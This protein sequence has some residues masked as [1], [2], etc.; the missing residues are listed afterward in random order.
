MVANDPEKRGL[1]SWG[2]IGGLPWISE[3]SKKDSN[4]QFQWTPKCAMIGLK[5]PFLDFYVVGMVM[6][7]IERG[8]NTYI[9]IQHVYIYTNMCVYVNP[10]GGM[11]CP[12]YEEFRPWQHTETS[13]TD[14]SAKHI[15]FGRNWK[16]T[17]I[18]N[19]LLTN[20]LHY[21]PKFN[22]SPWKTILSKS[23]Q[24]DFSKWPLEDDPFLF[25]QSFFRGELLNIGSTPT[26]DA[27]SSPPG[28]RRLTC[29]GD[30][31]GESQPKPFNL[32]R[33]H[34]AG[35]REIDPKS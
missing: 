33:W 10:K 18:T 32:P 8:L 14:W 15:Y 9:C 35:P 1:I 31:W 25:K 26:K 19:E 21:H 13:L 12:R 27:A 28:W 7:L 16:A 24:N 23:F 4:K 30:L 17:K 3:W 29:L 5:L 20:E 22:S 11:T 34:P 6:N 2:G